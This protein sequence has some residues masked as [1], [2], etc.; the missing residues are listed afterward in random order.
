LSYAHSPIRRPRGTK[1][2]PVPGSRG[3][4][5]L[6]HAALVAPPTRSVLFFAAT[7]GGG[8]HRGRRHLT[9][10]C[11]LT[12]RCEPR[13]VAGGGVPGHGVVSSVWPAGTGS[14]RLADIV[15]YRQ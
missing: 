6:L 4:R 12:A 14:S 9:A 7:P 10:H 5:R 1:K 15:V 11:H 8:F 3:G 2:P 13:R